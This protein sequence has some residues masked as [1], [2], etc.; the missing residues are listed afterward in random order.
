[1]KNQK[2]YAYFSS[3]ILSCQDLVAFVIVYR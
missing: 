3:V 2:N 1:M